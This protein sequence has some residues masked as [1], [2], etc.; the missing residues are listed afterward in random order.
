MA[1]RRHRAGCFAAGILYRHKTKG[2]PNTL[3]YSDCHCCCCC[4]AGV[5]HICQ[6][7]A[8][9]KIPYFF[10]ARYLLRVVRSVLML[11]LHGT[12]VGITFLRGITAACDKHITLDLRAFLLIR[13]SSGNVDHSHKTYTQNK[14]YQV[15]YQ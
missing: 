9:F 11:P 2:Y 8:L 4:C 5:H 1:D 14:Q 7:P 3:I 15:T 13:S 10:L 12:T 6:I